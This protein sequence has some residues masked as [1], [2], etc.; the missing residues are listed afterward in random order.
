MGDSDGSID[1]LF[2]GSDTTH[3]RLDDGPGGEEEESRAAA[4]QLQLHLCLL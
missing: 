1:G 4:S 3:N 2:A